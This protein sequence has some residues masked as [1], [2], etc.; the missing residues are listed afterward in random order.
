MQK[1]KKNE[2]QNI[3]AEKISLPVT[4]IGHSVKNLKKILFGEWL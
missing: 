4:S 3:S 1:T 2:N